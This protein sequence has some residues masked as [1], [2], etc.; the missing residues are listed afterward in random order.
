[1][2]E[3]TTLNDSEETTDGRPSSDTGKS[4]A[5]AGNQDKPVQAHAPQFANLV[6]TNGDSSSGSISRFLDVSVQVSAE[7]GNIKMPIGEILQ[8]D[9]GSVIELNRSLSEPVDLVAQ[10]IRIARGEVVVIDDCF[11]I[12]IK[13]IEHGTND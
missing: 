10:G 12:R 4:S 2:S 1:M 8:L 11:A 9:E 5:A 6:G 3:E 13:E 7:L